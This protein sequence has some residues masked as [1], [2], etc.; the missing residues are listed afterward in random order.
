MPQN[1]FVVADT[2]EVIH[3]IAATIGTFHVVT[4]SL[5]P[6]GTQVTPALADAVS[7][8]V[9]NLWNANLAA[10]TPNVVAY[11]GVSLRDLRDQGFPLVDSTVPGHVGTAPIAE[12]LP[13]QIAACLTI[14][15]NK[16]GRKYRGRMYW[17][18][19]GESANDAT[20]H[21][22][23]ACKTALDA[24]AAGFQAASNVSGLQL[25][26]THRPTAFDPITG[27][28]ISPGLGFT[29]PAIAVVCRDNVWDTQRRRA[30]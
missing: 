15:T 10:L 27:L 6:L 12:A 11:A 14:R 24:F 20:N 1:H 9:G 16:A 7:T 25:G 2:V 8:S 26:V 13:L 22:T 19:F 29:T 18:G 4:H 3:R 30:R 23:A 28:P 21:M 5:I 17:V